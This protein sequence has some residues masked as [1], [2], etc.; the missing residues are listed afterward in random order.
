MHKIV[1]D[2][3]QENVIEAIDHPELFDHL[4]EYPYSEISESGKEMRTLILMEAILPS[5]MLKD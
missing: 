4:F 5:E 2:W 1:S 3:G